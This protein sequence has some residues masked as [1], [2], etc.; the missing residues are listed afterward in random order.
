MGQP[1]RGS[2]DSLDGNLLEAAREAARQGASA[3]HEARGEVDSSSWSEKGRSDFVTEVDLEAER[4][5]L[6]VLLGRFPQHGVLAE[7]GTHALADRSSAGT[8]APES[9]AGGEESV[10][11]IRWI[12]DPLD[13]TTN[14]LHGYPEHAVSIA[15]EDADGIRAAVVLNSATGELFEA[16]RGGGARRNGDPIAVSRVADLRL[17][18][19]GTG[20]PFK[21]LQ[22]LPH[23]LTVFDR[24]LRATSGIRRGGAAALDL[25][26]LACGRLDAFFEYWL[27]PWDVAAGALIVREAGGVFEP[28]LVPGLHETEAAGAAMP[29]GLSPGGFLGA[30]ASLG[31]AFRLL[32]TAPDATPE[33]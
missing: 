21:K 4:R 2:C 17:A 9:A 20:F 11:A 6:S 29:S 8:P 22:V 24:V 31:E 3:H 18:L 26:D 5:I 33:S 15:A 32:V 7:E 14:W 23:Y 19:V 1:G 12:V 13:G 25:C 27:Q 30:N 28:L 10:E 16:S